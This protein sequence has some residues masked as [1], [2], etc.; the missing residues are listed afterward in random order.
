MATPFRTLFALLVG[1]RDSSLPRLTRRTSIAAAGVFALLFATS[2]ARAGGLYLNEFGTPSMGTSG[3]SAQSW[4]SDASTAFHNPAGMARLEGNHLMLGA[5]LLYTDVQFD[6][7]SNK[8]DLWSES[9]N[10]NIIGSDIMSVGRFGHGVISLL[11]GRVAIIGGSD[12]T[13]Q[14]PVFLNAIEIIS[15]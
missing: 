8:I 9:S 3:A 5:G 14:N 1:E 15:R 10:R 4:A 7:A 13:P 11:D 6:Q 12:G 2:P